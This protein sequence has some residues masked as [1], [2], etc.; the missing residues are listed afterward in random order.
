MQKFRYSRLEYSAC[1]PSGGAFGRLCGLFLGEFANGL[2]IV[3]LLSVAGKGILGGVGWAGCL[4]HL[5]HFAKKLRSVK[6]QK[7]KSVSGVFR[8]RNPA[9]AVFRFVYFS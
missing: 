1:L 8:N 4:I 5:I 2:Q 7:C 6:C 9:R 3:R